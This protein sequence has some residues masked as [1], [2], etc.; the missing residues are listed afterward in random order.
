MTYKKIV[1]V[2]PVHLIHAFEQGG[3]E[4]G[5]PDAGGSQA[6][7]GQDDLRQLRDDLRVA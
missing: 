2:L 1:S 6:G 4:P 7:Q 5:D 3:G